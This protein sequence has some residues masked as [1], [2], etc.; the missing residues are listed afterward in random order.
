MPETSILAPDSDDALRE[1]LK[2]CSPETYKAARKFRKTGDMR[3]V[4]TIV[5]GV[6]ERFVERDLRPKLTA[7][8]DSL[9]LVED[10]AIDSLSLFEIVLVTEDV[11]N[12]TIENDDLCRLRTLGDIK[13]FV[14]THLSERNC[15]VAA[16]A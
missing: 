8:D 12:I 16:T 15:A 5:H 1:K 3:A 13:R 11:L 7:N 4:P 2:R 6:I 10:L 14:V 9:R